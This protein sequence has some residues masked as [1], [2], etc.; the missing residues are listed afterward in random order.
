MIHKLGNIT[1]H[2]EGGKAHR[3]NGPAILSETV[4]EWTKHNIYHRVDGPARLFKIAP[5]GKKF[6]AEWWF[7]GVFQVSAELTEDVFNTH[8]RNE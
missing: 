1:I 3:E 8:W 6:V 7:E 5:N 2:S 4:Q